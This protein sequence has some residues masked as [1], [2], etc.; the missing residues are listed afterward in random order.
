MAGA[1]VLD[2]PQWFSASIAS[3]GQTGD[4][5]G[6]DL[7]IAEQALT[8]FGN[9][10]RSG[11]YTQALRAYAQPLATLPLPQDSESASVNTPWTWP[12]RILT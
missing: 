4:E 1:A 12:L 9:M 6:A 3:L 5:E 8:R 10:I 7:P 11:E 2:P